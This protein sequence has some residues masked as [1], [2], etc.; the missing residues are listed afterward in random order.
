M[1]Y[2]SFCLILFVF[3]SC[4]KKEEMPCETPVSKF[5]NGVLVLNE[6]LFQQNNTTLSF[7]DFNS[8]NVT[9]QVFASKN[10]RPLG[11]TGNDMKLYG[12]KVYIVMNNSG[13]LEVIDAKDATSVKQIPFQNGSVNY[14]PRQITFLGSKAYVSSYDGYVNIVDTSS[15]TIEN[16]IQVGANPE[17]IATDGNFIYVSNSGGLNFPNV[18]S[19]VMKIDISSNS[20]VETFNV[21]HNPG[22]VICDAQGDIYVVKRGDYDTD[23][24]ELIRIDGATGQVTNTGI[25][26]LTLEKD[27]DDIIIGYYNYTTQNSNVSIYNMTSESITNNSAV[28]GSAIN[29][30]YGAYRLPNGK[31]AVLDANGFT[32]SG[33]LRI[34]NQGNLES[35]FNVGLNPNSIVYYE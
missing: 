31:I 29:G 6:G 18:D 10:A 32:T 8:G 5:E 4:K 25:P 22:D 27:G 35:S 1:K 12:G 30:L 14:F 33:F 2:V 17:G 24:S 23:P 9:N 7:V 20:V 21:G 11:D 28:D 13:I 16:R 34:F 15:L 19:T 3:L 26:A